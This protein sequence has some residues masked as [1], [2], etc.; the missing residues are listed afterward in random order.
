MDVKDQA[1]IFIC[2]NI[3]TEPTISS[4]KKAIQKDKSSDPPSISKSPSQV[5]TDEPMSASQVKTAINY[6]TKDQ[7]NWKMFV[8]SFSEKREVKTALILGQPGTGKT[9]SLKFIKAYAEKMGFLIASTYC[10]EVFML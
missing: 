9:K 3:S 7:I 6:E 10:S 4:Q 1:C 2:L 5:K 8:K